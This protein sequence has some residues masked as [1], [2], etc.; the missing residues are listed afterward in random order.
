MPSRRHI[1][2]TMACL[3]SNVT[4]GSLLHDVD[5]RSSWSRRWKDLIALLGSSEQ[6]EAE[7]VL[8]KRAAQLTLQLEL[9]E[10]RFSEN[11]NGEATTQQI[12]VYQ[13]TLNTLRRVMIT[14]GINDPNKQNHHDDELLSAED[15]ELEAM[16]DEVAKEMASS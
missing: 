7:K 14:L 12:E 4:N 6:T 10:Q 15:Q 16:A 2:P 5:E 9:L 11:E 8:T 13:R 1:A 3:R